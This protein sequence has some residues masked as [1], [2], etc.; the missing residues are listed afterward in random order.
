MSP[1]PVPTLRLKVVTPRLLL[2]DTEVDEVQVPTIEGLI[3]V[4]PGHRPLMVA[5]GRGTLSYRL[6][7]D[8]ESY[9]IAG[10]TAEIHP[11]RVLIF[12]RM[13]ES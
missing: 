6:G 12:T 3:G 8:E 13:A 10:G 1:N 7:A 4:F 11:D 2:V 5:I 9:A